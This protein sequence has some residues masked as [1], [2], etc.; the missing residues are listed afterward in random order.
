LSYVRMQKQSDTKKAER[1]QASL[2]LLEMEGD[3]VRPK[4]KHTI[5]VDSTKAAN[6]FDVATHFDT[7]PEFA[8]R[9]FNRLR[10]S[11]NERVAGITT[12]GTTNNTKNNN[13]NDG[14]GDDK[15]HVGSNSHQKQHPLTTSKLEKQAR[16]DRI[17]ARKLAKARASSYGELDARRKRAEAMQLAEDH[18]I[19]EKL[20]AGKG[21]KRKIMGAEDGRPSQYKWRRKRLG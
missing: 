15:I 3:S 13:N 8:N 21:R 14:I 18:L 1:L 16:D 19:T 4:R 11:D 2:H 17:L 6:E 12:A 7:V 20:V 9:S 10:K 5:F